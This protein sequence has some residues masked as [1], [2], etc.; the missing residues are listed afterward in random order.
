MAAIS[1]QMIPVSGVRKFV[2]R[3]R[4]MGIPTPALLIVLLVFIGGIIG[5]YVAPHS[6]YIG[7][8]S[9]R[10][11]PPFWQEGGSTEYLLGTDGNGR[12]ILSRIVV[13]ARVTMVIGLGS[14][15]LGCLVGV[16]A[17]LIAGYAGGYVDAILMRLAEVILAVPPILLAFVL[18]INL[19]PSF[20]NAVIVIFIGIWPRFARMVRGEVV[21][22]KDRDYIEAARAIVS[23]GSRI[24]IRHVL[25]NIVHTIL[26]LT[27]WLIGWA[28]FLEASLSF[29]GAGVPPP[30]PSWGAMVSLGRPYL[31]SAWWVALLPGV[32]IMLTVFSLNWVGDW[33][34]DY[35]DPRLRHIV[36]K[37]SVEKVS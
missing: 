26:V 3:Y 25:P 28:I 32:A 29:L 6:A 23:S 22:I 14:T 7:N 12:G 5:P 13:G 24:M 34:R 9:D 35:T 4:R 27:T 30:S 18:A 20:Q 17:G 1:R 10:L 33:L 31:V 16:L 36:Q 21:S 19:G 15:A 11:T 2:S 8:L 37:V